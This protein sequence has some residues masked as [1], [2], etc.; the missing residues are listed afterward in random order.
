MWTLYIGEK[1]RVDNVRLGAADPQQEQW[2][3][4]LVVAK[5]SNLTTPPPF[6]WEQNS[7]YTGVHYQGKYPRVGQSPGGVKVAL[8]K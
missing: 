2:I 8:E 6:F 5:T 4:Q 1:H 7:Q 3:H